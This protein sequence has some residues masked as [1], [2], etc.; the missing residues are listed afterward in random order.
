MRKISLKYFSARECHEPGKLIAATFLFPEKVFPKLKDVVNE[1][2]KN[3]FWR[4]QM[5]EFFQSLTPNRNFEL[6]EKNVW[7][8]GLMP[9]RHLG[10]S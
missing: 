10:K 2:F 7:D 3:N 8:V 1:M 5:L 9:K 4:G 6:S